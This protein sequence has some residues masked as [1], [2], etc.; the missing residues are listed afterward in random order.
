MVYV[1]NSRYSVRVGQ[2]VIKAPELLL[3]HEEYDCSL[4]MWNAGVVFASIIFRKEPFFHGASNFH[5]L[6]TIARVLGTKGLLNYVEK[7]DIETTPNDVDA[8]PYFQKRDWRS[9]IDER[10]EKSSSNEAVDLVDKLLQ[11]DHKVS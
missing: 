2:G 8:I 9:F 7:Y 10:N 3:Q 4:D 6:Q 5:L 1:A 11:W